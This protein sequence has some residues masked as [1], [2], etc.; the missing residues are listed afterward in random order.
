MNATID[1]LDFLKDSMET[2][3]AEADAIGLPIDP[4]AL[5]VAHVVHGAQ[6]AAYAGGFPPEAMA[7]WLRALADSFEH[8]SELLPVLQW[9]AE[10]ESRDGERA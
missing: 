4:A 10:T 1:W 3:V 7:A 8:E 5:G 2:Q 6:I 9:R